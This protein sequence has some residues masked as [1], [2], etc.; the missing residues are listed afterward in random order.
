MEAIE[1]KYT[2]LMRLYTTL[3]KD[4]EA[5]NTIKKH[6]NIDEYVYDRSMA[7]LVKHFELFYDLLWKYLREYLNL[8]H[9]IIH[10]SPR[11]VFHECLKQKMSSVDETNTLLA[12]IDSRNMST[13]VYDTD[14]AQEV[15]AAIPHYH[16]VLNSVLPRIAPDT[17]E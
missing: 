7:S 3:G 9:G 12:M 1:L 8:K 16:T 6:H 11:S 17:V 5:H 10:N 14:I 2:N 4:I 13:H 15:S